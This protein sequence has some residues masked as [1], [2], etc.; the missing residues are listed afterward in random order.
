M[1]INTDLYYSD[2]RITINGKS[3][4]YGSNTEVLSVTVTESINQADMFLIRL[5]EHN[6]KAGR[7]SGGE[8]RWLDDAAIDEGNKVEI[9]LGYRNNRGVRLKGRITGIDVSLTE[10]GAITVTIR[11]LNGF[12]L[13]QRTHRR[14]PFESKTDSDIVREIAGE[15]GL[16]VDADDTR[17]QHALVSPGGAS[18]AEFLLERA[19]RVNFEVAVKDETLIFKRPEYLVHPQPSLTLTWGENIRNLDL[20][21]STAGLPSEIEV[22]NAHTGYGGTKQAIAASIAANQGSPRL[23]KTFGPLLAQNH[24]GKSSLLSDDQSIPTQAEAK[25][26]ATAEMER[27]AIDF[28]SGEG[29]C[30]GNPDL[31]SRKVI[32]LDRLGKRFSGTYT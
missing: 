16:S 6:A 28:I 27:R 13:L 31:L 1:P 26:V 2:Y 8:F 4:G 15:V 17:V 25:D 14:K 29:S 7:F 18:Y 30:I 23:G 21:T 32:K 24:L 22:R 12:L 20:N 9:E 11:G 19:R 5:R 3:Y 10:S